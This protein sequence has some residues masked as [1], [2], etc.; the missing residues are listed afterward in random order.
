ML[1]GTSIG[2][3]EWLFG[4]AVSAQYGASLYWLALY[5]IRKLLPKELHPGWPH[6]LGTVLYGWFFLSIS[7]ALLFI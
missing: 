6:Q 1:A 7:L 5:V 4:P 3:G 2:T